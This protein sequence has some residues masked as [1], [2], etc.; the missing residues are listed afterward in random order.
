MSEHTSFL[1]IFP[2]CGDYACFAG[3][4]DKAYVTDVQ[5]DRQSMSMAIS[6]WFSTMPSPAEISNL[7]ERLKEDYG[8]ETVV[9]I[10]DYPRPKNIAVASYSARC[11]CG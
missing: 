1:T 2:G 8:L 4:L 3:G 9:F 10:P 6:A 11:M 7:S 5:I